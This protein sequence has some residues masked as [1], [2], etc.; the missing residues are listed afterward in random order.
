V[1]QYFK[2]GAQK[3]KNANARTSGGKGKEKGAVSQA[4]Y[5]RTVDLA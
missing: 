1:K 4:T 5:V 3:G 2:F